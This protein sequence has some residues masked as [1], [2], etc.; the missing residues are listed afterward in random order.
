MPWFLVGSDAPVALRPGAWLRLGNKNL[1]GVPSLGCMSRS[2]DTSVR[3]RGDDHAEIRLFF[4]V[5]GR[6]HYGNTP[7]E[8]AYH[9]DDRRDNLSGSS[10]ISLQ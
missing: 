7:P 2:R 8:P 9:V 6:K 5:T 1:A 10:A 3:R 4:L